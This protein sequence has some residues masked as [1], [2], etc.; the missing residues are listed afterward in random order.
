M[1]DEATSDPDG[2][3]WDSDPESGAEEGEEEGVEEEFPEFDP[4][5]WVAGESAREE[6]PVDESALHCHGDEEPTDASSQDVL[7]LQHESTIQSYMEAER[8]ICGVPGATGASLRQAV[9][10]IMK[11]ETKRFQASH[12][13]SP[14]G[15]NQMRT[16]MRSTALCGK[17][18]RTTCRENGKRFRP[19]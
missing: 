1:D 19:I 3:P 8:L 11:H 10:K 9:A 14:L 6:T 12:R 7:V 13:S 18:S 17:S 16:T 4:D 5:D 15:I 2:R